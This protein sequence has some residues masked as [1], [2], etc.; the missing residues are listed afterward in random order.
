[1]SEAKE[2]IKKKP[3]YENESWTRVQEEEFRSAMTAHAL[4]LRAE[5]YGD[6]EVEVTLEHSADV[7]KAPELEP[8]QTSSTRR[9]DVLE[10]AQYQ[11]TLAASRHDEREAD[12]GQNADEDED[13]EE[14]QET[15][16]AAHKMGPRHTKMALRWPQDRYFMGASYF[17]I[18]IHFSDS[19]EVLAL[20]P[21]WRRHGRVP[22]LSVAPRRP[23]NDPDRGPR[24][25]QNRPKR[26]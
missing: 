17:E 24:R 6:I 8:E 3:F 26:P 5:K 21:S 20:C 15:V 22:G 1:M 12:D 10:E 9:G 25:P 16:T 18:F 2:S 7:T 19:H 14:Y 23:L 11:A 13:A 4:Q